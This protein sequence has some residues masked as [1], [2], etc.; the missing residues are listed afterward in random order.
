MV[1]ALYIVLGALLLIKLSLDI[2]PQQMPSL[3]RPFAEQ[4]RLQARKTARRLH[5]LATQ[6]LPLAMV[7][8]IIMEMNGAP[9]WVVHFCGV[10]LFGG[11]LLYRT[12]LQQ[13]NAL[14]LTQ[15]TRVLGLALLLM[16]AGN[17]CYLPW[18]NLFTLD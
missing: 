9:I 15:A 2:A 3:T 10:L 16:V 18:E 17:L 4:H 11:L 8:L 5:R 1:S 14:R 6:I 13:Q 12:G 7:L